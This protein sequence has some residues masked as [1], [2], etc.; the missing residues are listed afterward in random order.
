[1]LLFAH[2]GLTLAAGRMFRRTNLAFL[3]LGS[4][5]PD[6][7][8]KPL[9]Q[10]VHGTPAMGRT[11]SHTLLFLLLIFA[12]AIYLR[13]ARLTSLSWVVLAHLAL[14]SMW[15]SPVI[16]LWPLL[17]PFPQSSVVDA[18]R[19]MEM[20]L[21]GLKDPF[22]LVPECLGLVE[23]IYLL[24]EGRSRL[25]EKSRALLPSRHLSAAGRWEKIGPD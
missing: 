3:A 15:A 14:D 7:I 16:L 11:F 24:F 19:Y 18:W 8:D 2:V 6:I 13:D 4:M 1:M 10:L 22:I 23:V 5:L 25:L 9:G 20:L 17:G 21:Q 12:L